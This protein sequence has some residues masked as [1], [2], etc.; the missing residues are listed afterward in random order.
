[1]AA[2]SSPAL[3]IEFQRGAHKAHSVV[4]TCQLN[5]S[6][7]PSLFR[8]SGSNISD[9][10]RLHKHL[11]ESRYDQRLEQQTQNARP[12]VHPSGFS[13][14]VRPITSGC[15]Q[16]KMGCTLKFHTDLISKVSLTL[17]SWYEFLVTMKR[18]HQLLKCQVDKQAEP[19]FPS[20]KVYTHTRM[21]QHKMFKYK[22]KV[23]LIWLNLY[24]LLIILCWSPNVEL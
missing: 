14:L 20:Q 13:F 2:L 8:L 17:L 16:L 9:T 18:G 15:Y 1:M 19:M 4:L 22:S 11:K 23:W 24:P 10:C 6:R 7:R 5:L 12:V 3:W 21:E